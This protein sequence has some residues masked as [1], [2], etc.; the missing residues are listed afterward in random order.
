MSPRVY[1]VLFLCT[2]NSARSIM[3]EAILQKLGSGRFVASSAG[4]RPTGEVN[5]GA[6]SQLAENGYET[7]G[8]RSK[9]WH[10]FDA[11]D[12]RPFDFIVTVCDNAAGESCPVWPGR[13]LTAHWGIP[14]PAAA[15][16]ADEQIRVAF[17]RA[18]AELSARIE[19]LLNMPLESMSRAEI[20][21]ALRA[22]GQDPS[23]H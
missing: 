15:A 1:S 17:A 12:A 5:P 9:S 14:D 18:F 11:P 13:P 7:D 3:A 6:I 2:G 4:S 8:F 21:T 23:G 20:R 16:G 19:K 22:I 10:E